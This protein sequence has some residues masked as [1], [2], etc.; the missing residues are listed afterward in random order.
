MICSA[1]DQICSWVFRRWRI[2]DSGIK[3]FRDSGIKG[4]RDSGIKGFRDSGIEK[5]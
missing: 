1:V 5:F 3:G 4:F 2:R